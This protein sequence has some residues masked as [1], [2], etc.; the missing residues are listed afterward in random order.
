MLEYI[1]AKHRKLNIDDFITFYS[2]GAKKN[3]VSMSP[4]TKFA[5]GGQIPTLNNEYQFDDRLLT[6]FEDYSN[7]PVYVAVTDILNKADAVRSV[8]ALAGLSPSTI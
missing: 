8:Q 6:A 5:G 3:I 7:R 1:N 2:K 4:R